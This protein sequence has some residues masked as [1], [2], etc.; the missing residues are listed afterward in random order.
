MAPRP[1][2]GPG[3]GHDYLFVMS[4]GRQPHILDQT[5]LPGLSIDGLSAASIHDNLTN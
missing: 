5:I 3:S 4:C 1:G 2:F